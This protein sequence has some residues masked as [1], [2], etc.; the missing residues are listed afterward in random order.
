VERETRLKIAVQEHE[1]DIETVGGLATAL[2]G[3]VPEIGE[4]VEHPAGHRFEIL[5]ADERR[6][7][8]LRIKAAGAAKAAQSAADKQPAPM[9]AD[10]VET[11]QSAA[12]TAVGA[13][14]E[15]S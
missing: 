10:G 4:V 3:R 8:R 1:A 14:G 15:T 13:A 7:V 6:V 12:N 11:V 5:D 2:A 9:L